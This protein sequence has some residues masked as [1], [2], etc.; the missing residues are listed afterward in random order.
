M[1]TDFNKQA[2]QLVAS[3][4]TDSQ[5]DGRK[6]ADAVRKTLDYIAT[7][8]GTGSGSGGNGSQGTAGTISNQLGN[9]SMR[10]ELDNDQ[11]NLV[12]TWDK[13]TFNDSR[14][15]SYAIVTL[16]QSVTRG[17]QN[18]DWNQ[19]GSK[20][21]K[22]ANGAFSLTIENV[23]SGYSYRASVIG[24]TDDGNRSDES[25]AP[26]AVV[27]IPIQVR[28]TTP[29]AY[30]TTTATADGLVIEWGQQSSPYY[31]YTEIRGGD[32]N[33]GS[34]SGLIVKSRGYSYLYVPQNRT[35]TIYGANYGVSKKYSSESSS[36]YSFPELA[37]PRAPTY[38]VTKNENDDRYCV[39]LSFKSPQYGNGTNIYINKE[40][41]SVG[42][43]VDKFV[44][45]TTD[46]TL[47]VYLK[48]FDV[49]GESKQSD[50]VNISVVNDRFSG[51]STCIDLHANN[52]CSKTLT[53]NDVS[54][55]NLSARKIT[56][57]EITI[58]GNIS[59]EKVSTSTLD[60]T[61]VNTSECS[62]TNITA[63]E[64]NAISTTTGSLETNTLDSN[65]LTANDVQV[66]GGIS[67]SGNIVGAKVFN[68]V[69]N[70]YAEWFERGD[71][72]DVGDI[73]AL[74]I[75]T[76]KYRKATL[77]DKV[78]A[79]IVS[80]DYAHIIGGEPSKDYVGHNMKRFIP[81]CLV[82]RVPVK[83]LDD[84]CLGSYV[85]PSGKPGVGISVRD[86]SDK[87]VGIVIEKKNNGF[88]KVLVR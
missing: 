52:I 17:S 35:G 7:Y 46:S 9:F 84:P 80:G 69:Y 28:A 62:A 13:G 24:V 78:I 5:G 15:Y 66:T 57:H 59:T 45:Y 74:D 11:Y 81:V 47:S 4:P 25:K 79:G 26:S 63:N 22:S 60:S 38:T 31:I 21:Y 55:Q 68:A 73:V 19:I 37:T 10:Y 77:N 48:Y 87:A 40:K 64:V 18:V 1:A 58:D 3:I 39:E 27:Y 88:V 70:D 12:L 72:A 29:L 49:L 8:A 83:V 33:F 36:T 85:V 51:L 71:D 50:T 41:F 75:I 20:I 43:S 32:N 82:G 2:A 65:L 54:T 42:A 30:L 16:Q 34:D 56:T 61:S 67:A 53:S 6:F 76:G 86:W 14:V 44:Y 23:L